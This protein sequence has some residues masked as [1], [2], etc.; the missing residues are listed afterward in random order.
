MPAT[1]GNGSSNNNNS[2]SSGTGAG[3][4]AAENE[5]L[6]LELDELRRYRR[7]VEE[8]ERQMN[9]MFS[10]SASCI[11]CLDVRADLLSYGACGH[12]VC[13]GCALEH[14][15]CK[16]MILRLSCSSNTGC[17]A[18]LATFALDVETNEFSCPICRQ[19]T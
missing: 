18:R 14:V 19:G 7:R 17:T 8:R 4:S 15:R 2:G 13:V 16:L 5:G 12:M 6:L 10:A 3:A 11:L 1:S 9:T